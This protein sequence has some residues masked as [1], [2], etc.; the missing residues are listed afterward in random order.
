LKLPVPKRPAPIYSFFPIYSPFKVNDNDNAGF[1]MGEDNL[2][3]SICIKD[4]ALQFEMR[5]V[6]RPGR[7]LGN[8]Y[9]AF[10]LP[11]R[12]FIITT[13]R[14]KEG[15][16]S[17]R[18]NKKIAAL[19]KKLESGRQ[20]Q[21]FQASDIEKLDD[22]SALAETNRVLN[23]AYLDELRRRLFP[24]RPK[25]GRKN[26]AKLK[27]FFSRFVEGYTL[28][29]RDGDTKNDRL[30]TAISDWFG[31]QGSGKSNSTVSSVNRPTGNTTISS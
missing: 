7:F 2:L 15:I 6:L 20:A 8:H 4:G 31:R 16:R 26:R 18:R 28:M 21:A 29:E 23:F 30:T 24:P 9:L 11:M 17:A 14:V 12:T 1:D 27:S 3:R 10:T 19:E 5:A 13:D 25:G 22:G